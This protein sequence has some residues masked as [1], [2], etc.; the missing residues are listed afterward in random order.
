[1]PRNSWI[2]SI[3][4]RLVVALV[5][6]G[7]AALT[8]ALYPMA[9]TILGR[10]AGGGG[11]FELGVHFYSFMLSK[12]GLV[13][14]IAASIAGFCLGPERMANI[15][16]FFWGTHGFWT[17]L[18]VYL[19]EKRGELQTDHNVP[20]WLLIVPLVIVIIAILKFI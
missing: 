3:T 6:S 17:N 10:G 9:L 12:G 13:A 18:G 5:S 16:S 1:M 8:L 20:L 11:E 4:E 14:V 19:D 7:A 15:F 2:E